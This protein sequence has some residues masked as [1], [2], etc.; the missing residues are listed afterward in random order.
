MDALLDLFTVLSLH[1]GD[2]VPALQ[3]EPELGAVA[4]IECQ[5]KCRIGSDRPAA[6]QNVGDPSRRNARTYCKAVGAQFSR[7]H[8]AAENAAKVNCWCHGHEHHLF[9]Y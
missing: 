9:A 4:K 6:I 8:F 5:P 7:R 3:I 1:D 2:V